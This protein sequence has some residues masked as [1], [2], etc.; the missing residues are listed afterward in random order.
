MNNRMKRQRQWKS[1]FRRKFRRRILE[2][3]ER[4]CGYPASCLCFYIAK[5]AERL[6]DGKLKTQSGILISRDNRASGPTLG[7]AHYWNILDNQI[8]DLS[9]LADEP[10]QIQYVTDEDGEEFQFH[11]GQITSIGNINDDAW[12]ADLSRLMDAFNAGES[13]KGPS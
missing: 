1:D 6:S 13:E 4:E 5:M 9:P 7:T 2:T 10:Y 3:V 12:E 8:F 11:I